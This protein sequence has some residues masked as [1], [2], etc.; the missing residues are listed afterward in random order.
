MTEEQ[1]ARRRDSAATR[2]ALLD[3]ATAMFAARG[4]DRTTVRDIAKEAG[5]NQALLFRYFGSKE[6]LFEEAI[7]RGGHEQIATTKPGLLLETVLRNL[8]TSE[9]GGERNHT[10]RVFLR[11]TGNNEA[12]SATRRRLGE[13]YTRALASLTDA[14]DADLRADL[15]LAWLVGIT[16]LRDIS[17]KDPLA[18]ADA[19]RIVKLV[20]DASRTLLERVEE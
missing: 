8:L 20:L 14:E 15:V 4:F 3:A 2:E 9:T 13:D 1:R 10:L 17:E 12:A 6:S 5:V 18:G 7:A 19:D 11:S 16:F